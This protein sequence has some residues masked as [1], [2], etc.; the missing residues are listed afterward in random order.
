MRQTRKEK[1]LTSTDAMPNRNQSALRPRPPEQIVSPSESI[2]VR[3]LPLLLFLS[4]FLSIV[5]S[6]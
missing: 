4:L 5:R 2:F 6:E 3:C 1:Y